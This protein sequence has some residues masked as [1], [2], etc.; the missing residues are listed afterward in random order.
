LDPAIKIAIF[1][2]AFGLLLV[3]G[4]MLSSASEI[5][6]STLP[7]PHLGDP[8]APAA[9]SEERQEPALVGSEI[10]F[11]IQLPL[12]QRLP[13]GTFNR[14]IITNYYFA[15]TDLVQGPS[16]PSSFVDEFTV[17]VMDPET[18]ARMKYLYSV[19]TPAG[20]RRYLDE[21]HFDSLYMYSGTVIVSRW[22]LGMILQTV[23]EQMMQHRTSEDEAKD[24]PADT[25]HPL[26]H[27]EG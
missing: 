5:H 14:P 26:D 15:K 10:A 16:D 17:E 27:S 3:I 24:L 12:R 21:Q 23:V 1:L 13:N 22:D 7:H 18:D 4:R 9:E 11:P 19:A 6:A 20:L 25:P 2:A 8:I